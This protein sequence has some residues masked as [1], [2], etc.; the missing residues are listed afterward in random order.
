LR[1][2]AAKLFG[3]TRRYIVHAVELMHDAPEAA[4][5]V[6]AGEVSLASAYARLRFCCSSSSW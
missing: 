1:S 3:V 4:A 2:K 5:A 6:K